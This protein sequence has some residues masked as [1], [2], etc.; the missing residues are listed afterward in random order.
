MERLPGPE[1]HRPTA[2][3]RW[4]A[5]CCRRLDTGRTKK[6]PHERAAQLRASEP[7]H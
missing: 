5:V 4:A 7:E 1:C 3:V 6:A 2:R